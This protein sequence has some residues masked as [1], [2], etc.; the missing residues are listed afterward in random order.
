MRRILTLLAILAP[1]T[2]LATTGGPDSS[3]VI[4]SDSDE[5]DGPPHGLLD[6]SAGT[7]LSLSDDGTQTI[8]LPFDFSWYGTDYDEVTVSNNGALFFDGAESAPLTD[9]AGGS[10]TWSGV[11]AFGDDLGVGEVTWQTLG[12]YPHR[13]FAVEWLAPHAAAGGEGRIQAWLLEGEDRRQEVAIVLDDV[14]FGDSS[15][16]GGA[17]AVIGVQPGDGSGGVSWSC[18]GGRSDETTGWFGPQ[19][20]RPASSSRYTSSLETWWQGATVS[21]YAGRSL[22]AGDI[23]G[24]GLSDVLVGQQDEAAAWLFYG[25]DGLADAALEDA[26]VGLTYTGTDPVFGAS[27]L[28]DDY[29]GDGLAELIIGATGD[30]T[31]ASNAGAIYLIAGGSLASSIDAPDDLDLLIAG[32]SALGDARAGTDLAAADVDGDGYRDLIIG[33]PYADASAT[34]SGAVYV[35]Y[36]ALTAL[37]GVDELDSADAVFYGDSLTDWA[38]H[39]V[40]A[41]DL[42]GDGA[43]EIAVGA[44]NAD[45]AAN[46]AGIAY[47]MAGGALSGVYDLGTDAVAAFTGGAADDKA[48]S[49][50]ALGDIDGDGSGDFIF[51]AP[52]SDSGASNGG[53]VYAFYGALS[54][55]GTVATSSADLSIA[56]ISS[57]AST[58]AS[59]L[60]QDVDDDGIDDLIVGSPNEVGYSSGGGSVRV[61][62]NGPS[63]SLGTDDAD[64]AILGTTS[65]GQYATAIAAS[66][67]IDGDGFLDILGAAPYGDSLVSG[68]GD[69]YLWSTLPAFED[70]DGDGF[71]TIDSGGLDCDDADADVWPGNV[72]INDNL[73]DDD[74]DGFIDDAV[75]LRGNAAWMAYDIAAWLGSEASDRFSFESASSGD[76]LELH[77]EDDG[78][79]LTP[80]GTVTAA[81]EVGGA[82]A[83]DTLAAKVGGLEGDNSLT[84]QF[85]D[86]VD[87]IALRV[88]DIDEELTL[89]AGLDGG[90]LIADVPLSVRGPDR[91]GG[92]Y[93]GVLFT[94]SVDTVV[95]S[96]APDDVW[97]IDALDVVW[98]SRTDRDGDGYTD[99]GG[100]CDDDN[101]AVNPDATEDLTNG[102][103]DDC[104]GAIDGGSLTDYGEYADWSADAGLD[105]QAIDFED[106]ALST[107]IDDEY[108]DLGVVASGSLTVS[109][110]IDGAAPVDAQAGA[111]SGSV[112][113]I[114][115]E[116]QPALG[117]WIL[118]AAS[119]VTI[120]GSADGTALYADTFTIS[121]DDTDGGSFLGL[122]FDH[123]VHEL[124][125]S[126]GSDNFGIDDVLL[127]ALG[128]DDADGDGYT[129]AD[130]DCDD[131][132]ADASPDAEEVWYDGVDSDCDGGSDYDEDGDGYDASSYGGIDCDDGDADAS[133]DA[134]EVWYDGVDSDCDGWS[135]Y[136]ADG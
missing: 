70:G 6:L 60:A 14:T 31:G 104:D 62:T 51:G 22:A 128:L 114:F 25:V 136:D 75:S 16:D 10:G 54:L 9:C 127:S 46:N 26:D 17:S 97:G 24:D 52:Y 38:G 119:T 4:L 121:N 36:G 88:L 64:S 13:V 106:F 44:P 65:G 37:T 30:D 85:V 100:D 56:A 35:V 55:S 1:A 53:A 15:V 132:D 81:A 131:D 83:V 124:T 45:V 96:A 41:A 47:L 89:S 18:S 101:D 42:D 125:I 113:L 49:A 28:L 59:L 12:R 5:A 19:G 20:T 79:V 80:D 82:G 105:E 107:A 86:G 84:L 11:A 29:D 99:E 117:V 133:P 78:L 91:T 123:G 74:C 71:V 126:G 33:A 68:G 57:N 21:G 32:P 92:V 135:D 72:E 87:A 27:M 73:I 130:G 94:E 95:L 48:G 23:N 76:D 109:D 90:V 40:A 61:F 77:Y 103:D 7:V 50:V 3:G 129:E 69:I 110:D 116:L 120:A 8:S 34:Q 43:A 93:L 66:A 39:R 134:E 122:V 67:D 58:G 2:L 115:D 118:D 108:E 111:V 63:G 112:T 102:I 98:A